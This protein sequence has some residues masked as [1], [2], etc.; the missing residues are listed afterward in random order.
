MIFIK[1]LENLFNILY[2]FMD[3]FSFLILAAIGLAIIFGMMGVINLAH[4]EF[5]MLGAYITTLLSLAGVPI[6][7]A[8]MLGALGVGCFGFIVDKLIIRHLYGRPLDSVVATWGISLIMGQGMLIIMGPS[9][10]GLS[11]PLGSFTVG[12]INYSTYRLVL[13]IIACLLLVILY[14]VFMHT[15][16]GLRSRATMQNE[17]I[18]RSLGTNTSRMYTSTFVIGS[19]FAGLTGGLYSFTMSIGPTFGSGFLMES[20]VTVIVGG[21]NPLIGTVMAGGTL[22]VVH[23]GLSYVFGTFIGRV[24]LLVAAI[25][26]IRLWPTGFSGLI[27]KKL[28]RVKRYNG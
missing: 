28:I 16:F 22:G 23:S 21:A 19:M 27:E 15:K 10:Q 11:T 4:G 8:I 7:L 9:L 5:I 6:P 13:G 20:F 14:W 1:F 17:E 2:Q 12:D 26:F 25:L 3:S 18:A 24:G